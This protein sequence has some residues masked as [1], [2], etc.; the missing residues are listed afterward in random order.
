MLSLT[1][2][3]G[4]LNLLQREVDA[5]QKA[6]D[7]V[8]R[9]RRAIAP[10]KPCQPDQRDAPGVGRRA[11]GSERAVSAS[12][13]C[14]WPPWAAC[15][16]RW[17][18]AAAANCST[19]ACVRWKTSR[20]SPGCP[21]WPRYPPPPRPSCLCACRRRAGWRSHLAGASHE[22]PDFPLAQ[23]GRPGASACPAGRR[24]QAIGAMLVDAGRLAAE[25]VQRILDYQKKAGLLVRRSRRGHGPAR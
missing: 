21:S 10:A 4:E 19:A 1:K 2:Q 14:W 12:W 25:N 5:A 6:Y 8:S 22:Q 18:G 16:W 9:Q 23:P 3:R 13:R 17:H 15:C 11:A 24:S 20:R 7:V